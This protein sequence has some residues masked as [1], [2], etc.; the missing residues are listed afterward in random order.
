MHTKKW[1]TDKGFEHETTEF[2]SVAEAMKKLG[3]PETLLLINRAYRLEQLR[4]KRKRE[5]NLSSPASA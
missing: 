2:D 3:D 5:N 4:E 1:T